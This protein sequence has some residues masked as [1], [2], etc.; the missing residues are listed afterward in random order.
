MKKTTT[1]KSTTPKD[2]YSM[3]LEL[4]GQEFKQTGNSIEE[5]ILK[6]KP[7]KFATK[8]VLNTTYNKKTAKVMLNIIQMRKLFG[9]AGTTTQKIMIGFF[10]NRINLLL[11]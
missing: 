6:F 7:S 2:S 9:I 11:K 4:N 10:S 8:G 3:V 5:T 1:K